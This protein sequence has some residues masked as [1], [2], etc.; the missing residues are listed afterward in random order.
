MNIKSKIISGIISLVLAVTLVF[1]V[2]TLPVNAQGQN[3][4]IPPKIAKAYLNVLQPIVDRYGIC[5]ETTTN[6]T[7]NSGLAYADL[8]DFNGDGTDE[9]Y[10]YY[11]IYSPD[12]GETKCI[13]EVWYFN[14]QRAE[15]ALSREHTSNDSH[16]GGP[17]SGS[18]LCRTNDGKTYLVEAG[19]Y[20]TGTGSYGNTMHESITVYGFN[21]TKISEITRLVE[22][23]GEGMPLGPDTWELDDKVYYEYELSVNGKITKDIIDTGYNTEEGYNDSDIKKLIPA[24]IKDLKNKYSQRKELIRAG[25]YILLN[26][27]LNDVE[28]FMESLENTTPSYTYKNV[29]E[30]LSKEDIEAI[31]KE[32][33]KHLDGE[34]AA[35]YELKDGVYYVI[36]TLK[37]GNIGPI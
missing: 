12:Y 33:L 26:W 20:S 2:F 4:S 14:G 19:G 18:D 21:G 3:P 23:I 29:T 1:P 6:E 8:I 7:D 24:S 13:E 27:E 16:Y 11:I 36:V 32:I 17:T 22:T 34:I 9:L 37:D 30:N 28:S 25:S 10:F 31:I 15:N 35:I 5:K